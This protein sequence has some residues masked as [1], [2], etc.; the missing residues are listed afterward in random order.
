[1]VASLA[2]A[3]T[4][5]ATAAPA[6]LGIVFRRSAGAAELVAACPRIAVV[7]AGAGGA[8]LVRTF[9]ASCPGNEAVFQLPPVTFTPSVGSADTA[10]A[11]A[12]DYWSIIAPQA[13]TPLTVLSA[14]ERIAV[15]LAAPP[16]FDSFP[17]WRSDPACAAAALF[18]AADH[19]GAFWAELDRLARGDG[20]RGLILPPFSAQVGDRAD[21][22][23]RLLAGVDVGGGGNVAW[24][25]DAASPGLSQTAADELETTFGYRQLR[26]SCASARAHPLLVRV[27]VVGGWQSRTTATAFLDWLRFL[28]REVDADPDPFLGLAVH[29]FGTGDA[30]DV[31]PVASQLA[32]LLVD[33]AAPPADGGGDSGGE[34][35]PVTP[36]TVPGSDL[37]PDRG[38]SGGCSTTGSPATLA[39]VTLAL[40]LSRLSRRA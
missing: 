21:A 37:G 22:L 1:M 9:L 3:A 32:A 31:T 25:Y 17:S 39:L 28:D 8:E 5:A 18:C 35:P 34:G 10:R 29:G 33:P 19:V 7:D 23:C 4:L 2:L 36:P 20:F 27:S 6:D 15:W 24:T 40:A 30:N 12:F 26:T 11:Q 13:L 16:S 38:A 14:G